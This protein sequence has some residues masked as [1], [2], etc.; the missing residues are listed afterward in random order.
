MP[1]RTGASRGADR[2]N[3]TRNVEAQSRANLV[4]TSD[5]M[6]T[7]EGPP[8]NSRLA[9]Q[10][11]S[12][13]VRSPAR[14]RQA[15]DR[16]DTEPDDTARLTT[17]SLRSASPERSTQSSARYQAVPADSERKPASIVLRRALAAARHHRARQ[18]SAAL[19]A[20]SSD[21]PRV[22][23]PQTADEQALHANT[24][25][26]PKTGRECTNCSRFLG[27]SGCAL[28]VATVAC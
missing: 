13:A 11:V 22:A 10:P 18:S 1:H 23:N 4:Q 27:I 16:G 12:A 15:I 20:T 9:R 26:I 25:S 5:E 28:W 7:S 14:R 21:S 24:D 17:L 6:E 3:G 2:R 8:T 19:R